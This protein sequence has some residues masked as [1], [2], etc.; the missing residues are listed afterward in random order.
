MFGAFIFNYFELKS[1][2]KLA[3]VY[4][5]YILFCASLHHITFIF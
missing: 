2:K 1:N 5:N 3:L 4:E